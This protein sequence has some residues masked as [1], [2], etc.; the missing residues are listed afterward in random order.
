MMQCNVG[1]VSKQSIFQQSRRLLAFQPFRCDWRTTTFT[2]FRLPASARI[3]LLTSR[4]KSSLL[5]LNLLLR[6]KGVA[7]VW[8]ETSNGSALQRAS[9]ARLTIGGHR[10]S[11]F[12]SFGLSL[13]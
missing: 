11:D 1:E 5:S 9:S 6:D 13:E 7:R 10:L 4:H 3:K 8:L 12:S 2:I